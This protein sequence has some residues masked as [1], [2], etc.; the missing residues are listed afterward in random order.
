ME[1]K[2][3]KP[4]TSRAVISIA[5]IVAVL[6]V[7]WFGIYVP[8]TKQ[9]AVS[10]QQAIIDGFHRLFYHNNGTWLR[11]RWFG[12][13][14]QQNPNDV[15][16]IQEIIVEVKPDFI[17]ET[18]TLYGGSAVLWAM[19][20]EQV[21]PQGRVI[22][23]D[24]ENQ[25]A[26]ARQLRLFR[27]KVDFLLGSSTDPK[28]VGEIRRRV[29]GKRVLVVLDSDHRKDHVLKEMESYGPLVSVGS[30]LIVQDSNVN[31]HPV[32]KDFGPGPMEA[33]EAFLASRQEFVPD[34]DR[35]RLLFTMH[36][37]GYLKRMK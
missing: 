31:G 5:A 35:E 1:R 15:W 32:F 21:N 3:L 17:V 9:A 26:E 12:L 10:N 34:P 37:R 11:N 4:G 27:E 33:I 25:T 7:I 13:L 36:P 30:Y 8:R 20:L 28:I 16:I 29:E 24:I 2:G 6:A 19:I 22:T 14:T 18:G 23:V